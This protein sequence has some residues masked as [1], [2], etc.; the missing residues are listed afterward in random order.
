MMML[1]AKPWLVAE[2][3]SR[4]LEGE[5]IAAPDGMTVDRLE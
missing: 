1:K 3:L 5:V 2:R 4:E